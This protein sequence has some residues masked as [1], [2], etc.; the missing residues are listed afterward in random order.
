MLWDLRSNSVTTKFVG[1]NSTGTAE[2]SSI[3]IQFQQRA[4]F[5]TAQDYLGSGFRNLIYH[6]CSGGGDG[7][8]S[9]G[10]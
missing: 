10:T 5:S 8:V 1:H 6:V 4:S 3:F 7:L 9:S 2:W